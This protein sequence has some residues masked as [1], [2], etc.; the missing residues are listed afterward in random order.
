MVHKDDKPLRTVGAAPDCRNPGLLMLDSAITR[1]PADGRAI[2]KILSQARATP[3]ARRLDLA[4]AHRG[5]R[6]G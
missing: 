6:R 1:S 5:S 3:N 4:V 2:E